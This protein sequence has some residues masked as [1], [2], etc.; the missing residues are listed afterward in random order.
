MYLW[1]HRDNIGGRTIALHSPCLVSIPYDPLSTESRARN[2]PCASPPETQKKKKRTI[3]PFVK[4][5]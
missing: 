5:K 2:M 1:G 4:A 3:N